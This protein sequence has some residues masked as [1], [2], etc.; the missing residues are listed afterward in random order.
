M[1]KQTVLVQKPR[2][3]VGPTMR[4]GVPIREDHPDP[5]DREVMRVVGEQNLAGVMFATIND[6][7]F[8]HQGVDLMSALAYDIVQFANH[9]YVAA[10]L[11]RKG[12][13]GA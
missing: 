13:Q 5:L 1:P 7:S 12:E 9:A 2:Q 8:S 4:R 3:A 10:A 11:Q 6:E